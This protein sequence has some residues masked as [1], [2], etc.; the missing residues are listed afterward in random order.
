LLRDSTRTEASPNMKRTDR[1]HG[2]LP[3]NRRWQIGSS[4]G[5]RHP[6]AISNQQLAISNYL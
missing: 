1:N 3:Q 4:A 5:E 6:S 2:G